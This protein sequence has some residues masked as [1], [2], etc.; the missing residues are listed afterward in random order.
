MDADG[1][2]FLG[3]GLVSNFEG[4][5]LVPDRV[6]HCLLPRGDMYGVG[7]GIF[8][9]VER[10]GSLPDA[11]CLDKKGERQQQIPLANTGSQNFRGSGRVVSSETGVSCRPCMLEGAFTKFL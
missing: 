10:H 3:R 9:V 4:G 7:A 2:G 6:S 1:T 11:T 5:W 8:V